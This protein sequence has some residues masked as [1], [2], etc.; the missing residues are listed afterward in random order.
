MCDDRQHRQHRLPR[1]CIL[2][3]G[4]VGLTIED[5]LSDDADDAPEPADDRI[6][7]VRVPDR[8]SRLKSI[9]NS[10]GLQQRLGAPEAAGK[11]PRIVGPTTIPRRESGRSSASEQ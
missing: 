1:C 5:G 10:Q 3:F 2:L 9:S 4:E 7:I 6:L 8:P 11:R